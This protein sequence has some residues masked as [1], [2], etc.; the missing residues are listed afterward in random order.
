MSD[1]DVED[2]LAPRGITVS[3]ESI[4]HWCETVGLAD[5][6]AERPSGNHT[7]RL[8]HYDEAATLRATIANVRGG[9]VYRITVIRRWTAHPT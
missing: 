2:L 4:R 7:R 5:A 8:L 6:L 1:G 9:I 3:Y